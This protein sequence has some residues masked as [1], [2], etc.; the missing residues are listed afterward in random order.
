MA[1]VAAAVVVDTSGGAGL[2]EPLNMLRLAD[3]TS[4]VG[5]VRS[6]PSTR[7]ASRV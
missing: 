5:R 3:R 4:G 7:L 2:G 1:A 6:T